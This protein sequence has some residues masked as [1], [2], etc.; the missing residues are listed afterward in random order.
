M[1]VFVDNIVEGHHLFAEVGD[2]H[3]IPKEA[4]T[5]GVLNNMPDGA[6]ISTERQLFDLLHVGAG[7]HPIR[8]KFYAL[9]TVVRSGWCRDHIR[10]CYFGI[11]DLCD[12]TLDGL[13]VTGAEPQ[14]T[15]LPDEPYWADFVRVIEW[16][17]TRTS[18]TIWS[19]LAVHATVLHVD[20]IVRRPLAEKC[21]GI[22]DQ[23]RT[24]DH[25][26]LNGT[27]R[28]LPMPHSRWNEIPEASLR[29]FGYEILTQSM[30]SGV[31]IFAKQQTSCLFIFLQGHPEY[32]TL[33]LLGEYRRDIGR[34][35]RRESEQYPTMPRHYFPEPVQQLLSEFR[36]RA[37]R[38]RRAE[39]LARFPVA[40][41]S[42]GVENTWRR[43]GQQLYRNWL[44]LLHAKRGCRATW[45][46]GS[47][48]DVEKSLPDFGDGARCETLLGNAPETGAESRMSLGRFQFDGVIDEISA[49]PWSSMSRDDMIEV[50]RAYYFFS[51]QFRESLAEA[52]RLYPE[53]ENLRR[54]EAEECDTDNLSPWPNVAAVGERLNHDEYMRRTLAL[55]P[56]PAE[57]S[58]AI[59][60]IGHRYLAAT[61]SQ[62]AS[63]RVASL[64]SYED[65]GL[66]RVFK[67]MLTFTRWDTELLLA[68]RH[69]L[70]KHVHFDG[71]GETSH[72]AL[73]RHI[74]VDD[75]ILPL[76]LNFRDLL[77]EAVPAIS[78][79]RSTQSLS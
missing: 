7:D 21:I 37:I 78:R 59:E 45:S 51:I 6:L 28:V 77:L 36:E 55:M 79:A 18:S 67:A 2:A 4:L 11:D 39:F 66:E 42:L 19:C 65:G 35:L 57:K 22:F 71:D 30:E 58:Q 63:A 3:A 32:E 73:C 12:G 50:A 56:C 74:Q 24:R 27:Q 49:F 54:L 61:R 60:S 1:S 29:A 70:Q 25:P 31:G 72:G 8:L 34:F 41:A 9:P 76:W 17:K 14:A 64:V 46:V 5:I 69:F 75:G 40:R 23:S 20:G 33:S 62:P 16:A 15:Q 44:S 10:R 48:N 47:W 38:D 52:R 43:A 68:F 13:I 26:I 53:D